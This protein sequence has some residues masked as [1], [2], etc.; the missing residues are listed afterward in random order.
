MPVLAIAQQAAPIIVEAAQPAAGGA[1]ASV[2]AGQEAALKFD[3]RRYRVEGNTLLPV[4]TIQRVLRPHLGA[5]K[6]FSDV[7][8]AL[9]ALQKAYQ[10]AGYGV[11]QVT[12]PEQELEKGEIRFEVIETRL[13]KVAVQGNKHHS[14]RNIRGSVP[15]LKVGATP[16]SLEIARNLKV[17]NE[18]PAK[19][20]QVVLRATENDG[21]VEAVLKVSDD[22]P[23][24]Y[25]VS[26]D[27]TGTDQTG[28]FRLRLGYQHAN[29][30]NRDHTLTFQ[31]ITDPE[32]QDKVKVYGAGYHIPLYRLGD[33]LDFVA[34]YSNVDSG[35]VQDLFNV[36]G[37]GLILAARYN[38][39]FDRRGDYEHKLVFGLDYR[40]YQNNVTTVGSTVALVPDITVH[41]ASLVYNGTLHRPNWEL[42]FYAGPA[43]NIFPG[44]NDG[45]PSDFQGPTPEFPDGARKGARAG[46]RIWRYGADYSRTL[47]D[48]QLRAELNGQYTDDALVVGEQFG[49]GGANNV[50]GFEERQYSDDKGYQSNF[51]IYT[52]DIA[53]K[54]GYAGGHLRFLVFY[55]TGTISRNFLQPNEK[56]GISVDSV[57]VGL[58]FLTREVFSLRADFAYVL[59]D[60]GGDATAGEPDG[61]RGSSTLHASAVWVF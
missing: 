59:H 49:L 52:P 54:I 55:D 47:G 26:M 22:S 40:A 6:D 28:R 56:Y 27:N 17:A 18:N 4:R 11:V 44:G 33:S 42:G 38:H 5:Q 60:G 12:L 39:N 8:H 15:A 50:R 1:P 7:Q 10:D 58:R 34:G 24:K 53:R 32:H 19:S 35:T 45:A 25:S 29:L 61:R 43:Q 48:W 30:W 36:S 37:A 3:V 21:E 51:E 57:G 2:P 14:E 13:V 31:Y 23:A 41:P 20:T 9:E 46:Y 16:N